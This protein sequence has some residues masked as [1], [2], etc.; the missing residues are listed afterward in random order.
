[1]TFRCLNIIDVFRI[2]I[3]AILH[4]FWLIFCRINNSLWFY[5]IIIII[6]VYICPIPGRRPT[7]SIRAKKNQK[8]KTRKKLYKNIKRQSI[9][10]IVI[11]EFESHAFYPYSDIRTASPGLWSAGRYLNVRPL[12]AYYVS[13]VY[14]LIIVSITLNQ[15][16]KNRRRGINRPAYCLKY[17]SG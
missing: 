15:L 17:A 10:K 13:R 3:I 14:S 8:K 12:S 7:L 9:I 5:I 2:N 1:M 6:P 16:Q 11:L 4:L